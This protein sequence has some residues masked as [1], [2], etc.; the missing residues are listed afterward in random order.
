LGDLVFEDGGG[1]RGI[2]EDGR[3]GV[4]NFFL[5]KFSLGRVKKFATNQ[6]ARRDKRAW[7]TSDILR[8]LTQP[9]KKGRTNIAIE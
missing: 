2:F 9:P 3:G 1:K 8:Q 7:A 4:T 5:F 6:K